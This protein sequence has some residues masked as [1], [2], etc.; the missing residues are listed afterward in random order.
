MTP[1]TDV[2]LW[3]LYRSK[4]KISYLLLTLQADVENYPFSI[5][6]RDSNLKKLY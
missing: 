2:I 3:T 5:W 4:I 1:E 6:F